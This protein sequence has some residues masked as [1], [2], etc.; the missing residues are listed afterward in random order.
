M[1]MRQKWKAITILILVWGSVASGAV[2]YNSGVPLDR[3][4]FSGPSNVVSNG[5]G[6][7]GVSVVTG[8]SVNR[9]EIVYQCA[10]KFYSAR[11]L[12][13]TYSNMS[14][15]STLLWSSGN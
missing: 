8:K 9:G 10:Q 4:A 1:F 7:V 14:G 11:P 13:I 15:N 2:N 12:P 3:N 5:Y 6:D